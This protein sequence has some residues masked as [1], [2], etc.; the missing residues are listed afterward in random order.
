MPNL[1]GLETNLLLFT[2]GN[3]FFQAESVKNKGLCRTVVACQPNVLAISEAAT[4]PGVLAQSPG[5]MR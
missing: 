2:I 1:N 3:A 5:S 4:L